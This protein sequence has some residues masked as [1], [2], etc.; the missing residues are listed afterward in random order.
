[1]QKSELNPISVF[2]AWLEMNHEGPDTTFAKKSHINK[3]N[4]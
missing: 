1:M 2:M 4:L 3:Y